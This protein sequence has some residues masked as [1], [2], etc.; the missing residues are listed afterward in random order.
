MHFHGLFIRSSFYSQRF[1]KLPE[2]GFNPGREDEMA[3]NYS[4]EECRLAKA[5]V[6]KHLKERERAR[7]SERERERHTERHTERQTDKQK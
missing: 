4:E 5:V 6:T 2:Q 1:P 3:R 7:E